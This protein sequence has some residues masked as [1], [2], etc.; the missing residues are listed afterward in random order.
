MIGVRRDDQA[1]L[2]AVVAA[3]ALNVLIRSELDGFLG[4]SAIIG[5]SIGIALFVLGLRRRPSAIRRRGWI[6]AATVGGIA[7]VAVLAA[8]LSA[9]SVRSDI[10]RASQQARQAVD[11]LN[12]GDYQQ[13][14]V[15]FADASQAF[16]SVDRRLG[17]PL[18]QMALL[19]PGVAQN[20]SAGADLA[21]A[22]SSA[23]D[24]VATALGQ[25]D[26]DSLRVVDG[27]IDVDAIRA[28]EQPL[29]D[30]Q[31]SLTELRQ[32]TDDVQSP[33]L[34]GR[35][36]DELAELNA[37]FEDKEPRLQNAIDA[38]RLAP[39]LLGGDEPRRYL[40]MFT[41]PGGAAWHHRILRQ[42]RRRHHRRRA[43]RRDRVR[44]AIRPERVRRRRTAPPATA[45]PRSSSTT[46]GRTT[47]PM[48]P[49]LTWRRYGWENSTMP[50]HFPYI[51][52]AA[53]ASCTRRAASR[54]GRRRDRHRPLRGP[55]TDDLHRARSRC[56]SSA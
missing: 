28:V 54:A 15:L 45:A 20:V 3:V 26:P 39:Q 49:E 5:I 47:S 34:V 53:A 14:A 19:V 52:E 17:G 38:V 40:I 56:P 27:A 43:H 11:V 21:A 51:A 48:G 1:E 13:A 35:L 46:T 55:G 24:D 7:V 30:V 32:V 2:R 33:W 44:T 29:T 22:A 10:T 4:L 31:D 41:S 23:T 37:D 36:Q 16:E 42:L 25:V 12:T 6:A 8:G 9:M 50:A 18:G